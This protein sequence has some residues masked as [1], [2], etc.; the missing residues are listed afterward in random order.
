MQDTDRVLFYELLEN[1]CYFL[2]VVSNPC[3][4]VDSPCGLVIGAMLF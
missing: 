2:N 4:F 3:C 1:G